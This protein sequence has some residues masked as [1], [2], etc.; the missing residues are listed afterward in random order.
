MVSDKELERTWFEISGVEVIRGVSMVP[1]GVKKVQG[2][3]RAEIVAVELA[4]RG[5]RAID[6]VWWDGARERRHRW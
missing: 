2:L 5:W 3:A 6:L 4:A 1:R